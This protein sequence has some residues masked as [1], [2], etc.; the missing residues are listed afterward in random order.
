[1]KAS[2]LMFTSAFSHQSSV[3]TVSSLLPS[4]P[5]Y[6]FL[7]QS[8]S[9]HSS[10]SH[11]PSCHYSV[12]KQSSFVP[13]R[14]PFSHNPSAVSSKQTMNLDICRLAHFCADMVCS[15]WHFNS[16]RLEKPA[17]PAFHGFCYQ[18][19]SSSQVSVPVVLLALLYIQRFKNS[20]PCTKGA[21]SSEGRLFAVSLMLANKYLDDNAFTNRTWSEVT[22]IPL[23]EINIM[24]KEFLMILS[25]NLNLTHRE[26]KGWSKSLN[27]HL[28][29]QE[30]LVRSAINTK[31]S[32]TSSYDYDSNSF[33]WSYW[34]PFIANIHQSHHFPNFST[35]KYTFPFTYCQMPA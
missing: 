33:Y 17:D 25:F 29:Y 12:P 5:Y 11:P 15:I 28:V 22:G 8:V 2:Q 21:D 30:M 34:H 16:G 35:C 31:S 1:M 4:W 18:V 6:S 23:Q 26:L 19:L 24:E 9:H 13:E 7:D 20:S 3:F 14:S 27:D 32:V 10:F